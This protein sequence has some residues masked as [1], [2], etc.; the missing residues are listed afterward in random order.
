MKVVI[1]AAITP[2]MARSNAKIRLA[3]FALM[4]I[5]GQEALMEV[6]SITDPSE[7]MDDMVPWLI[8]G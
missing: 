2:Q 1:A 3:K 6:C 7:T 5:A 4:V 8:L